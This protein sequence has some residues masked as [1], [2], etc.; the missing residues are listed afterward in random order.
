MFFLGPYLLSFGC[1]CVCFGPFLLCFVV[2]LGH[3]VRISGMILCKVKWKLLLKKESIFILWFV[4]QLIFML[5]PATLG[6]LVL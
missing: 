6:L 2:A 4:D 5:G 3:C 1:V